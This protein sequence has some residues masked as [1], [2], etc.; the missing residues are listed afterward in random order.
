MLLGGTPVDGGYVP[1][2]L[3]NPHRPAS[4]AG[5]FNEIRQ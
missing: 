5:F 2:P 4:R 1:I 3:K